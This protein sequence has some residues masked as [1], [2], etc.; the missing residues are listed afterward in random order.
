MSFFTAALMM[1]P[2]LALLTW[3]PGTGLYRA[4]YRLDPACDRCFDALECPGRAG[5]PSAM[6]AVARAEG[7]TTA[8]VAFASSCAGG[9][10]ASRPGPPTRAAAAPTTATPS[11]ATPGRGRG[12]SQ[13][14]TARAAPAARTAAPASAFFAFFRAAFLEESGEKVPCYMCSLIQPPIQTSI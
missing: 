8:L 5:L 1:L 11:S 4:A 14:T 7:N 6:Y 2:P 12:P 3:L 9:L 10:R 13:P